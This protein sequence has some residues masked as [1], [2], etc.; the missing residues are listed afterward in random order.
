MDSP[1]ASDNF[2][3]ACRHIE[4]SE[5]LIEHDFPEGTVFHCA[6]AVEA[7]CRAIHFEHNTRGLGMSHNAA[8][9]AAQT[10]LLGLESPI[11]AEVGSALAALAGQ[12]R[13]DNLRNT[14][15][16]VQCPDQ[17][18]APPYLRFR[19]GMAREFLDDV[20]HLRDA[21]HRLLD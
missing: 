3:N 10:V 6:N 16:H 18:D 11:S 17:E 19:D 13:H 12:I 2:T 1:L 9:N 5:L 21:V 7:L 14:A 8:L 20:R 15:L 4:M